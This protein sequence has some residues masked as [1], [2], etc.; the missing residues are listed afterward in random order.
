MHVEP[1]HPPARLAVLIPCFNEEPTIADVVADF[2]TALPSAEIYVFDNNSTDQ[3]VAEARGAG[4]HVFPERQQGKGHV[5]QSMFRTVDADVYVLVDGDRTYSADAVRSLIEPILAGRADMVIGS[6]LHPQAA[7]D[8]ATL[9]WWGNR[10]FVVLLRVLFG[11]SLTDL[12]SG[13]RAL[14]RAVA[15]NVILTSGG[16]QVEA[17]LTIKAVRA[18]FRVTDIP[19]NLSGRPPGSHSK[20]RLSRDGVAILAEMLAAFRRE[21]PLKFSCGMASTLLLLAS[22]AL[23]VRPRPVQ[24]LVA[25]LLA[26]SGVV[27]VRAIARRS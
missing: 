24:F 11:I 4:A 1:C 18:G 23:V 22:V 6:R 16:F 15:R 26:L 17:E 19:V 9:N 21:E 2:R 8:F 12:L 25:L 3:S 20:I 13:Y 14:T 7:S 10:F 27:I 5:L